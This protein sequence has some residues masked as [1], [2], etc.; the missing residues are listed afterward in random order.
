M[1]AK[2]IAVSVIR[3]ILGISKCFRSFLSITDFNS[4]P[5]KTLAIQN[6]STVL[7]SGQSS[8]SANTCLVY[9]LIGKDRITYQITPKK[10][11]AVT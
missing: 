6:E 8:V 4:K 2:S 11:E 10:K 1:K 9:G 5:E 3:Q 7:R